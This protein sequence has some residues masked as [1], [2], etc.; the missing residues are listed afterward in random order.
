[1]N[2]LVT[3]GF[4]DSDAVVSGSGSAGIGVWKWLNL[5]EFS[6]S[7]SEPGLTFNVPAGNL[8]QTFQ[9]GAREDGLDFDAFVFGTASYTFTVADLDAGG[10]G[11][12]GSRRDLVS[13]NLIQFNDNGAWSWYMD[14]RA[15]VD[16]AGRKLIVGS[17]ASGSGVGSAPRNGN[18]EAVIFDLETGARTLSVLLSTGGHGFGCD[19]HNAPGFLVRPDN[20]YLAIYAGHNNNNFSYY[21]IYDGT[22]WGPELAFDWSLQPGGTDFPTTYSNPHYLPAE[23]RTYNLARGNGHGA[24]NFMLSTNFGSTWSYGGMMTTNA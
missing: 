19:D 4:T 13:G 15:V 11:T 23:G 5:S 14:E 20:R 18:I 6:N 24:Q 16:K 22:N 21:R 17:D 9:V 8:T 2:N 7:A 10:P 3:G 12:P 1:L